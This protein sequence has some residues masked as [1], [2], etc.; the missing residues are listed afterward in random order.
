MSIPKYV[1]NRD[2]TE[3]GETTGSSRF[4]RLDGCGGRC[5]GVRWPKKRGQKRAR[6]T[7]PCTKGMKRVDAETEQIM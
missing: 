3:R 2:G 4:C 5:I 1:L 6:I 7:F